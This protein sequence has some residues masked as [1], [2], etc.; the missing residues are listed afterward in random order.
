MAVVILAKPVKEKIYK[1]LHRII[2][3]LNI[4]IEAP[5]LSLGDVK[6]EKQVIT[7][8]GS[9]LTLILADDDL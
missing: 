2:S 7:V 3:I 1:K 5:V 8:E 6:Q 4:D 9:T